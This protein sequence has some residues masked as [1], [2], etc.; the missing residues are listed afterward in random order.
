MSSDTK[1]TNIHTW[2]LY[3]M[4]G[5]FIS[6]QAWTLRTVYNMNAKLAV[7]T[8]EL[9]HKLDKG[10]FSIHIAGEERRVEKILGRL[11]QEYYFVEVD[12]V[13][14][15]ETYNEVEVIHGR[16]TGGKN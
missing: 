10:E 4:L 12:P 3:T 13:T 9:E 1:T 6:L 5:L 11:I 2:A 14:G 8:V 16:R 15:E 7:V